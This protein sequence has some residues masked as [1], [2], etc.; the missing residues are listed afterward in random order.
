MTG[1]PALGFGP[2]DV[3]AALVALVAGYAVG[4][5]PVTGWIARSAG[6][7]VPSDGERNPGPADVWTIA[8]PGWGLLAL[9]ADLSKGILP[10]AVAT[11]TWS[12]G[13][14]WAA[15]LGA[16]VGAG[17]PAL[18]RLP[19]GRGVAVFAGVAF[20]LA[21]PAGIIGMLLALVAVGVTRLLRRDGR[22]AAIVVGIG[23]YPL[24]F[25]AAHHDLARLAA[26]MALYLVSALR[27]AAARRR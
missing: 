13:T 6:V 4:S 20:A 10:V 23:T 7:G 8:G 12:W 3:L 17:W 14:G 22:V 2:V 26:L 18:G 21:P 24:L 27:F 1:L 11:V 19:G 15:G 5:L 16:L 25:N 9:V